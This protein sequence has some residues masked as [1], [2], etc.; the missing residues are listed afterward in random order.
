LE[1]EAWL[2]DRVLCSLT[3]EWPVGERGVLVV[4]VWGG[5]F[6]DGVSWGEAFYGDPSTWACEGRVSDEEFARVLAEAQAASV[7]PSER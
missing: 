7:R 2:A 6:G 4:R 3:D 1:W 5:P